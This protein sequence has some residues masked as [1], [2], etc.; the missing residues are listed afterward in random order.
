MLGWKSKLQGGF[1]IWLRCSPYQTYLYRGIDITSSP[2]KVYADS[3]YGIDITIDMNSV[4]ERKPR[5]DRAG[6]VGK[7]LILV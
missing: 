7:L 2:W 4:L 1:E 3:A 6:Q 5:V